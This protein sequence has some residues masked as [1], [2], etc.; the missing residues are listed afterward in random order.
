[1]HPSLRHNTHA[2]CVSTDASK[3]QAAY[4]HFR[5]RQTPGSSARQ[6]KDFNV[7]DTCLIHN[8]QEW[9]VLD[10]IKQQEFKV[11]KLITITDL[12]AS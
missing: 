6:C 1:M 2:Y 12:S 3:V 4:K 7:L 11:L 5:L 10:K 8:G 9:V